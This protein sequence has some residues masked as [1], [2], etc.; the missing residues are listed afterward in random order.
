MALCYINLSLE[1]INV[2]VAVWLIYINLV[3]MLVSPEITAGD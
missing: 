1:H 2:F 3:L